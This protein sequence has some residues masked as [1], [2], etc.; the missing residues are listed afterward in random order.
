M[1]VAPRGRPVRQDSVLTG[2]IIDVRGNHALPF[3]D[4]AYAAVIVEQ[5]GRSGAEGDQPGFVVVP[6][7]RDLKDLVDE[8]IAAGNTPLERVLPPGIRLTPQLELVPSVLS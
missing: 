1:M 4:P 2:V 7:L 5:L 3:P 8:R 6:V